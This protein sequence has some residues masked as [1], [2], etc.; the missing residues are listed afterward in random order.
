MYIFYNKMYVDTE[1]EVWEGCDVY[2]ARTRKRTDGIMGDFVKYYD[3]AFC[4]AGNLGKETAIVT[5][6]WHPRVLYS[7][8]H[9]LYFMS[10]SRVHVPAAT[11]V[12]D[13]IMEVRTSKDLV[14]WSEP[15]RFLY[16]GKEFGNHYVAMVAEDTKNQPCEIDGDEFSLLTN[17][18]GTNVMRYKAKFAEK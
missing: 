8:K 2:V 18:N 5:R 17:H 12:I 6:S 16:K 9:Q 11:N 4:E 7:K 1:K 14:R 15:T 10:T 3:G 13:D